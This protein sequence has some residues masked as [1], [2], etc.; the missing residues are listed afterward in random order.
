VFV[1]GTCWWTNI[2]TGEKIRQKEWP[3]EGWKRGMKK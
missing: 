2:K 1:R 3:G